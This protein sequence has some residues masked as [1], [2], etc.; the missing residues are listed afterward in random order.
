MP[1]P[2]LT[3][4]QILAWADA[5]RERTGRWPGLKSGRVWE[6]ADEKWRALDH[7]LRDGYRGLRRG[8]SLARLLAKHRGRQNRKALPTYTIRQILPWAD[9]HKARTGRWPTKTSGQI[10]EAPGESWRAV[11]AA[12]R[13]GIRGLR[14]GS[15]LAKL[16]AAKRG[17]RNRLSASRLTVRQILHWAD[18]HHWQTGNW[19][20]GDSGAIQSSPGETWAAIDSAL[21]RGKRGLRRSSLAQL[22]ARHRMVRRHPRWPPLTVEL[23][24]RWAD[25]HRTRT[26]EWPTSN[27]GK[28]PAAPGENWQRIDAALRLGRRGLPGGTTLAQ[29]L[30]EHRGRWSNKCR[31]ALTEAQ[32]LRWAREYKRLTGHWPNR[33]SG[34]IAGTDGETWGAVRSA[35]RIGGRGLKRRTTM[36]KLLA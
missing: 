8:Q 12:L 29:L 6:M 32:I 28:V 5:H 14:G 13:G 21:R 31:P 20:T 23:V 4:K 26:G 18:T 2:Q 30:A 16:L 3:V 17:K 34:P 36:A 25:E 9:A 35:L 1:R 7:A 27:S 15:S 22:L 33:D 10:P 19:P 11:E 24:L